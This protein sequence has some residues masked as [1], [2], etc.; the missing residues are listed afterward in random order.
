MVV[1]SQLIQLHHLI[2]SMAGKEKVVLAYP[3]FIQK[4][5]ALWSDRKISEQMVKIATREAKRQNASYRPHAIQALGDF[6]KS[7]TDLELSPQIVPY[8]VELCEEP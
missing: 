1:P 2:G 8:L 3:K 7:R 5:S 4:A 6:A